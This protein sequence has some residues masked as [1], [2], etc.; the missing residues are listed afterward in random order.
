MVKRMILS[1]QIKTNDIV[2]LLGIRWSVE[3][4]WRDNRYGGVTV[5]CTPCNMC[6]LLRS[7]LYDDDVPVPW[8]QDLSVT[9]RLPIND[10][11]HIILD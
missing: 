8:G 9:K 5:V 11:G 3:R 4:L 1:T 2:I 10:N 6:E 7:P